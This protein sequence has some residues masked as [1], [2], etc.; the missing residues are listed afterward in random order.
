[1]I[2]FVLLLAASDPAMEDAIK[3]QAA[4]C[5][6][7]A[8]QLI[9]STDAAG[10]RRADVS[11]NADLGRLPMRGVTCLLDWAKRTGAPVGFI[12]A[13]PDDDAQDAR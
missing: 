4:R 13:P 8:R 9:W 3:A 7:A 2:A 12:A 1:V 11:P 10:R 6:L 5:G